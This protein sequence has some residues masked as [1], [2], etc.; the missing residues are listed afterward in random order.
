MM[1]GMIIEL[2]KKPR[3]RVLARSSAAAPSAS[4]PD[5]VRA[6]RRSCTPRAGSRAPPATSTPRPRASTVSVLRTTCCGHLLDLEDLVVAEHR[7]E[8]PRRQRVRLR[9]Q[10]DAAERLVRVLLRVAAPRCR[11][12]SSSMRGREVGDVGPPS[13]GLEVGRGQHDG[14][15]PAVAAQAR[16]SAG[17]SSRRSAEDAL[18]ASCS[19]ACCGRD[20]RVRQ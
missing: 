9:R 19:S 15:P 7:C 13:V 12:S 5:A 14:R 10:L 16:S 8:L 18:R 2:P 4:R 6:A 20:Q 17:R 1:N 3:T 11:A